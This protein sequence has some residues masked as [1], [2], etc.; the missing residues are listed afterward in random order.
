MKKNILALT[1]GLML[2]CIFLNAQTYQKI[3]NV[4]VIVN[5]THLKNPWVG[6]FDSPIFQTIDLN[7][8]GIKDLFVFEKNGSGFP[9]SYRISTFINTGTPNQTSY[10]LFSCFVFNGL[11]RGEYYASWA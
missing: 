11:A 3:T 6:G 5:G 4:P 1:L 7:G 2:N 9:G 8:D 10:V